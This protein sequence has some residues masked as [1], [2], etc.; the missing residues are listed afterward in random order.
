MHNH[1]NLVRL[2]LESADALSNINL[3]DGKG[4]TALHLAAQMG[5]VQVIDLLLRIGKAD[6]RC[7]NG[8]GQTAL[9]IAKNHEIL[10]FLLQHERS[11]SKRILLSNGT[12]YE[13][14]CTGNEASGK[15]M[16]LYSRS[17]GR[18]VGDVL[19]GKRHGHGV[20]LDGNGSQLEGDFIDDEPHGCAVFTWPGG[21]KERHKYEHGKLIAGTHDFRYW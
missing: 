10:Q 9:R 7:A 14:E 11:A 2:F 8:A 17:A 3:L 18:Y 5:N 1:V 16:L 15:G 4:S 21:K 12:A 19:H 6:V 20:M 13:G